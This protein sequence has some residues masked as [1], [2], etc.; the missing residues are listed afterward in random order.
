MRGDQ[1]TFGK[2][3]LVNLKCTRA[4]KMHITLGL[5]LGLTCFNQVTVN[6]EDLAKIEKINLLPVVLKGQIPF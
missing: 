4:L 1:L 3:R 2:N 5:V 6:F